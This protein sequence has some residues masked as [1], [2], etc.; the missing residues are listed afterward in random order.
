VPASGWDSKK[1]RQ[2]RKHVSETTV[3]GFRKRT[4]LPEEILYPW[5]QAFAKPEFSLLKMNL[6]YV[7]LH[8]K[9]SLLPSVELLS[10]TI[11]SFSIPDAAFF[12]E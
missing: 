2:S 7:K 9:K 11:I 1:L 10:T 3:S 6:T 5:L 8:G 12:T 4:N